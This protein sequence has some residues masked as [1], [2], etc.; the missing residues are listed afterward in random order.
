M[1]RIER[2]RP[3]RIFRS[4]ELPRLLIMVGMLV[5][6]LLMIT[7]ARDPNTWS[8]LVDDAG[9]GKPAQSPPAKETRAGQ[10]SSAAATVTGTQRPL[11]A[12][13]EKQ[14]AG[15]KES[16][17]GTA[18]APG[19]LAPTGPTDQDRDE[20]EAIEEEFQAVSDGTLSIR[21]EE[22]PAYKRLWRWVRSQ[23]LPLLRG[24]AQSKP[25]FSDLYQTPERYRGQLVAL[26]L[27][28]RRI[29]QEELDGMPLYEVWGWTTE[30]KAWPYVAV[31]MD[32]PE[33]MPIGAAVEEEAT[34]VGYFF[35]LQGYQPADAKPNAPPLRAPLLVG[36]LVWHPGQVSQ[37]GGT[38]WTWGFVL[39]FGFMILIIARW[40]LVFLRE[41]RR[42][43]WAHRCGAAAGSRASLDDWLA[44]PEVTET[45]D[46]VSAES[47]QT[48]GNVTPDHDRAEVP[49][50]GHGNGS[51]APLGNGLDDDRPRSE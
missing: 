36:R 37:V 47:E 18:A 11:E 25:T 13:V 9:G 26:E 17:Q 22:M 35:K 39:L 2:R 3:Q 28:V 43:V 40:G 41:G 46:D 49:G 45:G 30:S 42:T 19:K 7:R 10:H 50:N 29:L 33:G 32:L 4:S 6:L 51:S 5:V 16:G 27:H 34:V 48:D 14:R 31:V 24:R 15:G 8:W 20:R 38:D 44:H 23:P 21:P 1:Q 12:G